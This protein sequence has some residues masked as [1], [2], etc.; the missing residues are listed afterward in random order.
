MLPPPF[1]IVLIPLVLL[2]PIPALTRKY[3]MFVAKSIFWIENLFLLVLFGIYLVM[4]DILIYPKILYQISKLK[5]SLVKRFC[6]IS[7]WM[8]MG[9]FY[10]VCLNINDLAYLIGIFFMEKSTAYS[11]ESHESG[12][13]H[14]H[15]FQIYKEAIRAV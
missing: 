2:S 10:L 9:V 13:S 1:N 5:S 15:K 12:K 8:V 3:G 6:F 4:L 7:I 11:K 14:I